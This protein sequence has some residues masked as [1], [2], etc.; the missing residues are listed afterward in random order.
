M[1]KKAEIKHFFNTKGARYLHM[2]V[3]VASV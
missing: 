2:N 3:V 1:T